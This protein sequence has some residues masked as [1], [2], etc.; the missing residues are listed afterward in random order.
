MAAINDL[1]ARIDIL[2]VTITKIYTATCSP[3]ETPDN[4]IGIPTLPLISMRELNNYENFLSQEENKL[5]MVKDILFLITFRKHSLQW[6]AS[7]LTTVPI[8]TATHSSR[9][10]EAFH[11]SSAVSGWWSIGTWSNG[12]HPLQCIFVFLL[13]CVTGWTFSRA[14]QRRS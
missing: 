14:W 13:S 8:D 10:L 7:H 2:H 3:V 1:R 9:C 4:L 6:G 11:C 12:P 5:M